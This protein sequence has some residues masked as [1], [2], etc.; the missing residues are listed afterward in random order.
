MSDRTLRGFLG[1][2]AALVACLAAGSLW[3]HPAATLGILAGGAWSLA[4]LWC[5]ARALIVW[6]GPTP[7]R[8]RAAGWFLAK[9][10]GLYG[11]AVWLWLAPGVSLGGF[12]L[13]FSAVLAWAVV[14]GIAWSQR[15]LRALPTHGG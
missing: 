1:I 10:P 8:W 13:G 14:A 9:F 7:P 4:N 2:G 6:L 11:L 3:R 15:S 12:G 5:L